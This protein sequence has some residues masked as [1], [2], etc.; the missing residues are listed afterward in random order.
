MPCLTLAPDGTV[1]T[2]RCTTW[3]LNSV[4]RTASRIV[5][6]PGTA[7]ARPEHL[8][9]SY[10]Y[11][12]ASVPGRLLLNHHNSTTLPTTTTDRVLLAFSDPQSKIP[13]PPPPPGSLVLLHYTPPSS[14]RSG[15]PTKPPAHLVSNRIDSTPASPQLLAPVVLACEGLVATPT[16][17]LA[18]DVFLYSLS[19][20]SLPRT[21]HR[22]ALKQHSVQAI[23]RLRRPRCLLR[24]PDHART[25]SKCCEGARP[26]GAAIHSFLTQQP[27]RPPCATST[28]TSRWRW[29]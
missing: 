11:T 7:Q 25:G 18:P 17:L 4:L 14:R 27:R 19:V 10:Y 2:V 24:T 3:C 22:A 26:Q 23:Q 12:I 28:T 13:S 15:G 20:L 9:N 6:C 1:H 5:Q 16:P 8:G 21:R 29:I